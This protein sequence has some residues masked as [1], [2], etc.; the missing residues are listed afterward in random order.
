M[1]YFGSGIAV[2]SLGKLFEA[3][4][5][6]RRSVLVPINSVN[7]GHAPPLIGRRPKRSK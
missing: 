5:S 3:V 2:D 4:V 1:V 6:D 7:A